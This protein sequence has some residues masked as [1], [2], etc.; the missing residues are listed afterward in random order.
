LLDI[1]QTNH[2]C[3]NIELQRLQ[4]RIHN[5]QIWSPVCSKQSKKYNLHSIAL[6]PF[7]FDA[8]PDPDPGST[9]EKM[10]PDPNP[11]PDLGNFFNIF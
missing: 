9:L 1:L 10:D 4:F 8:D 2:F 5:L 6:D 3:A 11:D 7:N